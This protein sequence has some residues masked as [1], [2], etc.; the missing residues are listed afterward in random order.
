MQAEGLIRQEVITPQALQFVKLC[1]LARLNMVV[2]GPSGSGTS[3]LLRAL[4]SLFDGDEQIL[5]IQNPDEPPFEARSIT[6]LRANLSPAQGKPR[7][8]RRYLL[9][10]VPKMH[11]ERL[12]IERVQGSESVPLLKLLFAMDGVIFSMAAASPEKAVAKLET[13]AL[14]SEA[15]LDKATIRRI[16]AGSLNLILQLHETQDGRARITS[17]TEVVEAEGD[18]IAVRHVFLRHHAEEHQDNVVGLL[19]P[20]GIKP[21]FM[22]RIS[23]FGN[24]LP[25]G[26]L[27]LDP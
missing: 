17:I 19:R 18:G 24:P 15:G 20:T 22:D 13:M 5:A 7:I 14:R 27:G 23:M 1:V 2:S 16:L 26:L 21:R 10:L 25:A 8:T 4:V 12:L 3:M 11:P 6:T 9:T